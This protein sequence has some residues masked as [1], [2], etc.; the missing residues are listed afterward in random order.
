MARRKNN[1]IRGR[2]KSN[3][4]DATSKNVPP[5]TKENEDD[6]S[7][8]SRTTSPSNDPEWYGRDPQLLKDAASIPFSFPLGDPLKLHGV[9]SSDI[10]PTTGSIKLRYSN[11]CDVLDSALQ[12][13]CTLK[14]RPSLGQSLVKTDPLNVCANAFYTHVRYVNSGRKNYDPADLMIYALAF[15]DIYSFTLW[16]Q[17]LYSYAF[18]F[19][20]K[21]KYIAKSLIDAN[22]VNADDITT[23]LANF[24]YWLNAWINKVSSFA[25]PSDIYFFKRRAFLYA[26][27]YLENPVGNIKD[28]LY[29]FAPKSF[30]KFGLDTDGKGCLIHSDMD[31]TTPWKLADIISYANDLM[32]NITG[33]EDF[34][35]M[36]G[37][38][39]K[40]YGSNIISL[41]PIPEEAM[42][43][44]VYDP[45]VLS[46]FKN[47]SIIRNY[48][49]MDTYTYDGNTWMNGSVMQS[50][51]GLLI[52]KNF[53]SIPHLNNTTSVGS[54]AV[55][56]LAVTSKKIL[57]VENPNPT[58]D[59]VIEATRLMV[60]WNRETIA[61][62][63]GSG[64]Q[65]FF[66][67]G[68]E[69]C[70]DALSTR[71]H[72]NGTSVLVEEHSS[73]QAQFYPNITTTSGNEYF[74]TLPWSF[75]SAVAG[76]KY[77]PTFYMVN[78]LD[79]SGYYTVERVLPVSNIDNYT[80]VDDVLISKLHECALLSLFY[81]PGV[82]KMVNNL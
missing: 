37:D 19:S 46:Q 35:L 66:I 18:M 1:N 41:A 74:P 24:R 47:A 76:M 63:S 5:E 72:Y 78:I 51:D 71:F 27:Y 30:M 34:G 20:Q 68:T 9:G 21:N 8:K 60:C 82:A 11:A 54:A 36:S 45:Y 44:P 2:S 25:V 38:I 23:N 40:A 42:L 13:I 65:V 53:V 15:A 14:L 56:A 58:P 57:T 4:T 62:D 79:T 10:I 55:E 26:N 28:Q 48:K 29:Q 69:I 80:E 61:D 67:N 32:S 59:D 16:A 6:S 64:T 43:L 70:V 50:N 75:V 17:R 77:F 31:F 73:H 7:S 22:G 33:D 12:G 3:D 39:L 52:S 49:L 81:V